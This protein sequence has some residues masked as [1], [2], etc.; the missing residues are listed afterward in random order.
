MSATTENKSNIIVENQNLQGSVSMEQT[1][2]QS[3]IVRKRSRN[4]SLLVFSVAVLCISIVFGVNVGLH[5]VNTVNESDIRGLEQQAAV[6][7][8]AFH[9]FHEISGITNTDSDLLTIL[10]TEKSGNYL[11]ALCRNGN[12]RYSLC[13]FERDSLFRD[14]WR[15]T[16]GS[17]RN[18]GEMGS[19]NAGIMGNAVLVF[20][21]AELP[22]TAAWYSFENGGITYT[23]PIQ[24]HTALNLFVIL[25]TYDISGHPV[26]LN[27]ARQ[28][29]EDFEGYGSEY[30]V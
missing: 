20:F 24:E 10:Q 18:P 16:G 5:W 30:G 22:D 12:G 25:D 13:V 14:R 19:L 28:P 9:G 11:A 17:S 2:I 23:C 27:E 29:L 3:T 7:L 4:I 8:S 1:Q 21:G 26:L 15:A 6:Y